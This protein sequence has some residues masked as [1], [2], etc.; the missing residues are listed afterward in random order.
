[1]MHLKARYPAVIYLENTVCVL[2]PRANSGR[3]AAKLRLVLVTDGWGRVC[4]VGVCTHGSAGSSHTVA[5]QGVLVTTHNSVIPRNTDKPC[6][7]T[8]RSSQ[9]M[10]ALPSALR[11][12]DTHYLMLL[13]RFLRA[14]KF[15][16]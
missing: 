2:S 12:Q 13:P 11:V 8:A 3:R 14:A 10:L 9:Q 15:L 4:R 6:V 7:C 1:M 5:S 16:P